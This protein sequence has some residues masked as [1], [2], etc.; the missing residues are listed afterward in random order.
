MDQRLKLTIPFQKFGKYYGDRIIDQQKLVKLE[1]SVKKSPDPQAAYQAL[2]HEMRFYFDREPQVKQITSLT[3]GRLQLANDAIAYAKHLL[4]FGAGNQLLA[5]LATAGNA[6]RRMEKAKASARFGL[7]QGEGETSGSIALAAQVAQGATCRECASLVYEFLHDKVSC[8]IVVLKG[9][10]HTFVLIGEAEDQRDD[11]VVADAWPTFAQ[12][13]LLEDHFV[14]SKAHEKQELI[15]GSVQPGENSR[16]VTIMNLQEMAQELVGSDSAEIANGAEQIDN[17]LQMTKME[18]A[19]FSTLT[20]T[21]MCY[22]TEKERTSFWPP[23]HLDPTLQARTLEDELEYLKTLVKPVQ[24]QSS[25]LSDTLQEGEDTV[26]KYIQFEGKRY[27]WYKL[28]DVGTA[29]EGDEDERE[30]IIEKIQ[31]KDFTSLESYL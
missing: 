27:Y 18:F 24:T 6:S 13:L 7:P 29:M 2:L 3:K 19:P 8:R 22:Q 25:G 5:A 12:A 26:G 4:P 15:P 16:T 14:G 31:K 21:P 11:L 30:D 28:K 17:I 10:D 23:V 20:L 1:N 9:T